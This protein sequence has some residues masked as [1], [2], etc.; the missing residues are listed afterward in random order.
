MI[1]GFFPEIA[2]HKKVDRR[3]WCSSYI[4]TYLERDIRNLAKIGDLINVGAGFIRPESSLQ[5]AT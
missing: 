3:L 1:R 4:T 2:T 5:L